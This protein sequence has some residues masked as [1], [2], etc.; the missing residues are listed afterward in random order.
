MTDS[1]YPIIYFDGVC[2]LCES[3]VQFIIQKNK[4]KNLKFASLQGTHGQQFL[5]ENNFSTTQFDSL[6]FTENGKIYTRSSGALRITKHLKGLW[7]LFFAFLII[8]PFIRNPIYNYVA[9]NRYKWYGKKES[10]WLPSEELR[11]RFLD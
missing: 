9:K 7:I 1:N 5:N 6:V 3:S 4:K 2:N 8:P 10:C 11:K